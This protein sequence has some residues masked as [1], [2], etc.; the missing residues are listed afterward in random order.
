M[1]AD[2]D[3]R[4]LL[5]GD[6]RQ[7][8]QSLPATPAGRGGVV[9]GDE[10]TDG[11]V[12]SVGADHEVAVGAGAV[13]EVD[14]HPARGLG[15]RDRAGVAPDALSREPVEEAFQQ[16]PPGD[17]PG[18][19]AELPGHRGDV[20]GRDPVPGG[21]HHPHGRELL[22]RRAHVDA[23]LVEDRRAVGPDGDRPAARAHRRPAF[24]DGDVVS[25]AQQAACHGDPA[26]PG[27]DHQDTQRPFVSTHVHGAPFSRDSY[28]D[29]AD[30]VDVKATAGVESATRV[31]RASLD[32]SHDAR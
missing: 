1:L 23:Q 10:V 18:G 4:V 5:V 32:S 19:C 31:G 11:R 24:E 2:D 9:R 25:V 30:R 15:H 14:P 17:H 6:L 16:H 13:I 27:A 26:D 3:Q 20:E 12:A 28:E 8:H 29:A 7:R 22:A 21:C